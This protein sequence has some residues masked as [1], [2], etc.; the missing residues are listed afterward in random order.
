MTF[1]F[2]HL[3]GGWLFGLFLQAAARRRW[4]NGEWALLLFGALLPD[5][6]FLLDLAFGTGHHRLLTHSILFIFIGFL[7]VVALGNLAVVLFP[8]IF[9]TEKMLVSGGIAL[10]AGVA[11]HL[12][13]DMALGYPG[14]PVFWPVDI[15]VW[16]FGMKPFA[17]NALFSGSRETLVSQ[18][19][20]AVVEMGLGILWLAWLW[21]KDNLIFGTILKK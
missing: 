6:D 2:G 20:L 5:A 19:K 21:K 1:A 10:A 12:L 3:L 9:F 8:R 13:L 11:S 4:T 7:G 14:I 16:F 18:L 17:I 15:G